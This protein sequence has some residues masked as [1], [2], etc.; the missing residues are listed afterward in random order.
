M[1]MARLVVA[2]VVVEGRSKNEVAR[3]YKVSRR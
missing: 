2:A 1:S 3:D